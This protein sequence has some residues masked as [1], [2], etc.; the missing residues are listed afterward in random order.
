MM[1]ISKYSYNIMVSREDI[2]FM[3]HANNARYLVWIQNA[4]VEFWKSVATEQ[5]ISETLWVALRHD[6]E[7]FSPAFCGNSLVASV[8]AEEIRGAR[9]TFKTTIS[10]GGKILVQAKSTWCCLDRFS[11]RPTRRLAEFLSSV[12][13]VGDEGCE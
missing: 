3:G 2:D 8:N 11:G 1:K 7:Y 12:L 5:L 4:I 10:R 13:K 9:S 6:I